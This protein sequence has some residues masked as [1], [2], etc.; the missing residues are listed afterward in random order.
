MFKKDPRTDVFLSILQYCS[1]TCS[2]EHFWPTGTEY[3]HKDN[4]WERIFLN[5]KVKRIQYRFVV[6]MLSDIWFHIFYLMHTYQQWN[7][8]YHIKLFT[9]SI[10]IVIQNPFNKTS[11]TS[12]LLHN[13]KKLCLYLCHFISTSYTV[14]VLIIKHQKKHKNISSWI[15]CSK[16]MLG[17]C[18]IFMFSK[19]WKMKVCNSFMKIHCSLLPNTSLF[20]SLKKFFLQT[21]TWSYPLIPNNTL[22]PIG[23]SISCTYKL[24]NNFWQ[25]LKFMFS[26]TSKSP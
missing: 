2:V 14:V 6:F 25:Q 10:L 19:N 21:W 15:Y 9:D 16:D 17:C 24:R 1:N 3:Y 13:V 8:I 12:W 23:V 20:I 5:I 7:N 4:I 22:K 18:A 11:V 26:R